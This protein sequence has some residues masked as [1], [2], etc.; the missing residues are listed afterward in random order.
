MPAPAPLSQHVPALHG[1]NVH[2]AAYQQHGSALGGDGGRH[3]FNCVAGFA[4]Q[5]ASE[6]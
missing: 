4:L 2:R 3:A 6:P 5:N 1:G